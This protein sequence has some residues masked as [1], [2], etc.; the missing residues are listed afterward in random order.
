[1]R[2]GYIPLTVAKR[3]GDDNAQKAALAKLE[4]FRAFVGVVHP[5]T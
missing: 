5:R 2:Q 4:A 3:G 1:M